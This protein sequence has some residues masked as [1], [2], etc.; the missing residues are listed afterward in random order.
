M[1][2]KEDLI[3][4]AIRATAE[5]ALPFFQWLAIAKFFPNY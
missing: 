3:R 4:A 5:T 2:Q 1:I